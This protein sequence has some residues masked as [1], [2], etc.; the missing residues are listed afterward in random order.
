MSDPH[1]M[2]PDE[3]QQFETRELHHD[4]PAPAE[5][6]SEKNTIED[7]SGAAPTIPLPNPD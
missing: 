6:A 3:M 5:P 4:E 2:T 7:V 1:T